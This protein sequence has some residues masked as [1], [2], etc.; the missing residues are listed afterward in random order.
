M[1]TDK[2]KKAALILMCAGLLLSG[3][4]AD[5]SSYDIIITGG[6]VVDGTGKP[7]T[8]KDIGLRGGGKPVV[9]REPEAS[10]WGRVSRCR[11]PGT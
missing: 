1:T 7:G 8:I 2:L 3:G 11:L 5:T 4:C 9:G 10:R 6:T